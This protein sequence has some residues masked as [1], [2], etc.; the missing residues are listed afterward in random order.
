MAGVGE[1]CT[2]VAAVLFF[3][4]T[5]ARID[6]QTCMQQNCQWTIPPFQEHIPYLTVKNIDLGSPKCKKATTDSFQGDDGSESGSE[7]LLVESPMSSELDSFY[8]N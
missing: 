6:T 2:H 5:A 3:L 8:R 4:E 1:V 7:S